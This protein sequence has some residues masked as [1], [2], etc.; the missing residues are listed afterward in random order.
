MLTLF[1]LILQRDLRL[2]IRNKTEFANPLI[3]FIMIIV[4]F[5]LA[6]DPASQLLQSSMAGIIWIAALLAACLSL[7][8]LFQTDFEEGVLEQFAL[9]HH[10]LTLIVSAKIVAHWLGF[11][12]PLL[13]ITLLAAWLL[14]LPLQAMTALFASLL[15]GTPILSLIGAIIV[16]LTVGLQ[17]SLLLSL[18]VLPLYMPVLIFSVLAVQNAMLG[19]P[20]SAELYFLGGLLMLAITLAPLATAAAL[21]VKLS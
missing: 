11:G 9:S 13:L 7:E 16:A 20:I 12:L 10:S 4:L 2:Y 3:F 1:R 6:V 8:K 15:L 21:R 14:A 19:L 18:L 17:T 5:A